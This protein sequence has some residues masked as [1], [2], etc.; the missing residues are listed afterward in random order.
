MAITQTDDRKQGFGNINPASS[1]GTYYST[2][3]GIWIIVGEG[4]P[5]TADVQDAPKG[6]MYIRT[7]GGAIYIKTTAPDE[8]SGWTNLSADT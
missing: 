3:G 7:E 2:L 8:A 1:D 6:T 4:S 5:G